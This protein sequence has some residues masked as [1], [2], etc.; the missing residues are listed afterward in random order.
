MNTSD[1]TSQFHLAW[2]IGTRLPTEAPSQELGVFRETLYQLAGG[3]GQLHLS[4]RATTCPVF[5]FQHTGGDYQQ[6]QYDQGLQQA[7]HKPPQHP[8][9]PSGT[10]SG[11]LV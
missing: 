1:L 11:K 8:F 3:K 7:L 2:E 5:A 10:I 4:S 6:D 9:L